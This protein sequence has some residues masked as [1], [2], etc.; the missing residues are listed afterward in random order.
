MRELVEVERTLDR[1][2]GV[3]TLA[4]IAPG[5]SFSRT[6]IFNCHRSWASPK[7]YTFVFEGSFAGDT[8]GPVSPRLFSE[9]FAATISPKPMLF[10]LIVMASALLGAVLKI[11]LDAA[12]AGI[13]GSGPLSGLMT[14]RVVAALK[15]LLG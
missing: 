2:D 9:S 4:D 7:T 3:G 5:G 1:Q 15:G 14:E 13:V 6:F 11:A 10:S 8:G 12:G